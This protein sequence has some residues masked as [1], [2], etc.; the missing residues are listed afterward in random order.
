MA[1]LQPVLVGESSYVLRGLQP[2]EDRVTLDRSHQTLAELERVLGVMGKVVAW[3]QLRSSGR[4]G[5]AIADELIAFAQRKKWK[6]QLLDASQDCATRVRKDWATYCV[7][8]DD[9]LFRE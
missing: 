5:S 2:S 7:A 6:D 8:F 3:A 1:F 4:D 9:G